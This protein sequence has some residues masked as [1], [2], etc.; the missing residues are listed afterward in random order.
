[1]MSAV[2]EE[3]NRRIEYLMHRWNNKMSL[4]VDALVL[5]E[6]RVINDHQS[7]TRIWHAKQDAKIIRS[8]IERFMEYRQ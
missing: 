2:E 8:E 7:W 4:I 5:A 1:M 3:K 6:N